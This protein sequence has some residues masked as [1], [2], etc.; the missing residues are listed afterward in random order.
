MLTVAMFRTIT[1]LIA[2]IRF[3]H[4]LDTTTTGMAVKKQQMISCDG[5]CPTNAKFRLVTLIALI[6]LWQPA[7]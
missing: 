4:L 2:I 3:G 1:L 5:T 7:C 6:I